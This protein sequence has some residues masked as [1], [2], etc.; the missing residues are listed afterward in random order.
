MT[1]RWIQS[2][3]ARSTL[4]TSSPSLEKSEARIDGAI[5]SGRVIPEGLFRTSS[6]RLT[7]AFGR[8]NARGPARGKTAVDGGQVLPPRPVFAGTGEGGTPKKP[9]ISGHRARH[10]AC[11]S[12]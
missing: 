3:P 4:R 1:S 8:G 6:T 9:Y 12:T 10:A 7:W 5:T 11:T 2:A